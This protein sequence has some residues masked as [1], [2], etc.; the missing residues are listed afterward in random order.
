MKVLKYTQLLKFTAIASCCI[1]LLSGCFDGVS[2]D[3]NPYHAVSSKAFP[4]VF[5][6]PETNEITIIIDDDTYLLKGAE[7]IHLESGSYVNRSLQRLNQYR[8]ETNI[9]PLDPATKISFQR[10]NQFRPETN[11]KSI[12]PAE[13]IDTT[14][15]VIDRSNDLSS[16]IAQEIKNNRSSSEVLPVRAPLLDK[17]LAL[18]EPQADG[19][20]KNKNLTIDLS[21]IKE[22]SSHIYYGD[23]KIQKVGFDANGGKLTPEGQMEQ[24][25]GMYRSIEDKADNWTI[26]Y[27]AKDEKTSIV[28][29]SDPTCG[30]C[31]MLHKD[32]PKLND[33][34]VSVY[35]LYYPRSLMAGNESA[36]A[37]TINQMRATWCDK[38][39]SEALD[40]LYKGVKIDQNNECTAPSE[41]NRANFP[42]NEHYLLG[43]I[44][45]LEA[46]PLI[47]SKEGKKIYGYSKLNKLLAHIIPEDGH[48][49]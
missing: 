24:V 5:L 3:R 38:K 25:Q 28:V 16:L 30:F 14:I 39:P 6:D 18:K 20:E 11:I 1:T 32:I 22:T 36:A 17:E 21:K 7:I 12:D 9:K 46:T 29:F 31:R 26:A 13:P 45:N 42:L 49:P 34:G 19:H 40:K 4:N 10:L 33:A 41:Q 43:R 48:Q 2:Q 8:Q 47:I 44:F 37:S 35:I 15:Q 27:K 23:A